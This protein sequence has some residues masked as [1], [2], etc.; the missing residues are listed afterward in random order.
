LFRRNAGPARRITNRCSR[1]HVK[2]GKSTLPIVSSTAS[3]TSTS[4]SAAA[5]VTLVVVGE[6]QDALAPGGEPQARGDVVVHD[7]GG[8]AAQACHVL[9]G[10]GGLAC[11][12]VHPDQAPEPPGAQSPQL[13]HCVKRRHPVRRVTS[14]ILSLLSLLPPPRSIT[15]V[16]VSVFPTAATAAV[17]DFIVVAKAHVEQVDGLAWRHVAVSQRRHH[18]AVDAAGEE[19]RHAA[20]AT[21]HHCAALALA[22]RAVGTPR[23]EACVGT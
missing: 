17:A 5:E 6:E 21:A 22:S 3:T 7:G 12:H 16:A 23:K 19:H 10:A 11:R 20:T 14:L 13:A 9:R 8:G 15:G 2:S 1:G 4:T 18:Y